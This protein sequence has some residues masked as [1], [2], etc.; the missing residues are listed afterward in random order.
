MNFVLNKEPIERNKAKV[1]K[2]KWKEEEINAI[3]RCIAK[4]YRLLFVSKKEECEQAIAKG[5]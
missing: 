1:S 2:R 5:S 3:K 4:N